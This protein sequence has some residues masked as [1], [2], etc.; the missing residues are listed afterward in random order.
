MS[1][2]N[3]AVNS[4]LTISLALGATAAL[5]STADREKPMKI[6]AD[7]ATYDQKAN[8]GVYTGNVV[9]TQ[10]TMTLR[11]DKLV[12]H[13]DADGMQYSQGDG[14]PVKFR[15]QADDGEWVDAESLHYD[16]NQKTGMLVL[17]NSAWVRKNQNEVFGDIITYNL[18]N[19][20]YTANST[21][22]GAG[23]VNVT[24]VPKKKDA[25][26]AATT[27]PAATK[28]SAVTASGAQ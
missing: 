1:L 6:E 11:S 21:K 22:S 12:I 18:N 26:A 7:S 24:I 15:Q 3:A 9:V 10:G 25:S 2:R 8:T 5:A 4:V 17:T 19:D 14:K 23:R 20:Q 16:Y 13:Q 27:K 28:A